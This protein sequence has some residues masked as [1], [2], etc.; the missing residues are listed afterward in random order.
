MIPKISYIESHPNMDVIRG[1]SVVEEQEKFAES[2][3][4]SIVI[5]LILCNHDQIQSGQCKRLQFLQPCQLCADEICGLNKKA[6]H[7]AKL[8]IHDGE[9]IFKMDNKVKDLDYDEIVY[10]YMHDGKKVKKIFKKGDK[11]IGVM[12]ESEIEEVKGFVAKTLFADKKVTEGDGDSKHVGVIEESG[13]SYLYGYLERMSPKLSNLAIAIAINAALNAQRKEREKRE[14]QRRLDE[15][16]MIVR[17]NRKRS[18]KQKEAHWK[19]KQKHFEVKD[20]NRS[21]RLQEV[22]KFDDLVFVSRKRRMLSVGAWAH[23]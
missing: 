22:R 16:A 1:K 21:E 11:S 18:E 8:I 13:H 5:P 2:L 6:L 20:R 7:Y 12:D 19:Q 3:V 9:H 17:D 14:Q 4:A 23:S 15:K 10:E